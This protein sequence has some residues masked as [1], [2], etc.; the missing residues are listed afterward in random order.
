MTLTDRLTRY[1]IIVKIP[2]Y[3]AETCRK[4]LQTIIDKF[5]SITFDNG[6]KFALLN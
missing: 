4:T 3:H 1:D 6:N 5:H 2:D